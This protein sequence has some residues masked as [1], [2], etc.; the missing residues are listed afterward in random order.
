M[1][2]L[3]QNMWFSSKVAVLGKISMQVV[4]RCGVLD[5][6]SMGLRIIAFVKFDHNKSL[7]LYVDDD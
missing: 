1:K 5:S 2:S 3:D 6:R 4:M 7:H